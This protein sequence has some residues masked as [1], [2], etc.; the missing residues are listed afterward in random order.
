MRSDAALLLDMLIA[1]EKI[2]QFTANVSQQQFE[3]SELHQS[4]VIRELQVIG[5]AARMISEQTKSEH[6]VFPPRYRS[7]LERDTRRYS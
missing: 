6:T 5:E 7:A 2:M 3:M 1:S 4:A